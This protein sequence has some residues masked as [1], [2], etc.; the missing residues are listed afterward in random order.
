[1]YF[2]T[3]SIYKIKSKHPNI[4]ISSHRNGYF[5]NDNIDQIIKGINSSNAHILFIGM[6]TPKKELFAF[7]NRKK[8]RVPIV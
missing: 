6:Q 8:L 3:V 7:E 2:A 1:M 4:K 5:N